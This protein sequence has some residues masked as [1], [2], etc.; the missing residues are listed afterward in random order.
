VFHDQR[1]NRA[2][3]VCVP[4][5]EVQPG[6]PLGQLPDVF[7]ALRD[8]T[9]RDLA[10]AE[11]RRKQPPLDTLPAYVCYLIG[12][13]GVR[14]AEV[15]KLLNPLDEAEKLK[16]AGVDVYRVPD[17]WTG[18]TVGTAE[19][20]PV[21]VDGKPLW[22]IDRLWPG[23][24]QKIEN[25]EPMP[26]GG[27]SWSPQD[28]SHGGQPAVTVGA[29]AVKLSVRTAWP[30]QPG[31]K[32]A[33]LTFIAPKDGHYTVTGGVK[34]RIWDGGA[35]IALGLM[36]L[37]RIDEEIK[38]VASVPLRSNETA[39]LKDLTVELKAGEE[40]SFVPQFTGRGLC[41]FNLPLEKL[42]ITRH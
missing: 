6:L 16:A 15:A 18:L 12:K 41:A 29:T 14:G 30:G 11:L 23:N 36:K 22:R 24:A 39:V 10:L 42:T 5:A 19:G 7:H 26:W 21:T 20:N 31:N 13:E 38:E 27:V 37:N 40:L 9:G 8:V 4:A 35:P 3:V 33:V 25:F 34:P 1:R 2:V 17:K 32:L 28:H